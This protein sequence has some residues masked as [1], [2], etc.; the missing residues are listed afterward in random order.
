MERMHEVEVRAVNES[1]LRI[2]IRRE[3]IDSGVTPEQ[4]YLAQGREAERRRILD[5]LSDAPT[6]DMERVIRCEKCRNATQLPNGSYV[7]NAFGG[8]QVPADGYCHRA[9]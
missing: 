3:P 6:V 2:M 8:A 4:I 5:I 7:C 9:L 1:Y